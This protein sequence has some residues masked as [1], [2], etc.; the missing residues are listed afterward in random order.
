MKRIAS[1]TCILFLS[2]TLSAQQTIIRYLSG[3]DKDHTVRWDFFCTKGAQSGTWTTIPV[4]SNWELQGFGG[5]NYGH[6]KNK[7]DE[8]GLYKT[9]FKADPRW[10]G[11]QIE[12]VFEGVMTDAAVSVNGSPAG[13]VHQGG[14]YEFSYNITSLIKPNAD[15]LL[16]VTVSKMSADSS[17]NR[18]EREGDFWVFGG[19]YRP[20]YLRI[21]PAVFI[22]RVAIDAKADGHFSM[23]VFTNNSREGDE[24]TAEVKGSNGS[25]LG[26]P[27]TTTVHT[28]ESKSV[29]SQQFDHPVLWNP[30]L[31]NLYTVTI[32]IKRNH[33]VLHTI[34]QRFGFRTVEVRPHDGIYINNTKVV[35]KGVNRHSA[36]PESGRTLSRQI[37]LMDINLMKEMNMN[38]V[39]MSHY[40]PDPLFLDLCDSLGL[41]VLD[42]LTGWQ[43]KYATTVGRKLVKELVI[44]DVNHPS[45]IFWDNGNE[46]GFNFDLDNDYALYDPQKRTVLHPWQLFN[47]VDTKHYPEYSYVEKAAASGEVLLHTEMIHGLYDGGH[48]AGLEDYWKLIRSNP[49]H[50]GG[51]LWVFADEG[52]VRKD[53]HD[54]IDTYGNTAPDGI[55]GPHREKEASFYTIK[56]IWSPVQIAAPII[57]RQFTGDLSIENNYHF[58]NLSACRFSWQLIR[59]PRPGDHTTAYTV[60]S[61]NKQSITAAP[62]TKINTRMSLPANWFAADAILFKAVDRTGLMLNEWI[63]PIRKQE[64]IRKQNL[65][66]YK[67]MDT[68]ITIQQDA[69]SYTVIQAGIRYRFSLADGILHTVSKNNKTFPFGNGPV[70]AGEKQTL[71]HFSYYRDETHNLVVAA[72]YTGRNILDVK[73]IFSPNLPVKLEYSYTQKDSAFYAG[74]GFSMDEAFITGMKWLG[75]GPYRVWKNR[76]QG[77]KIG[78]WK[79]DYNNTVTGETFTYPEFKGYHANLYWA[80]IENKV[81]PFT[82]YS[83]TQNIFLQLLRPDQQKTKIIPYVNPPFPQSGLGFMH[84]IPAIGTKFKGAETMGPQSQLNAP[85]SNKLEGSLWFDFR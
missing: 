56:Q 75:S 60:L 29:L 12:L 22:E 41:F 85:A 66:M 80:T 8:Q 69:T 79:K 14:F 4:P 58:T 30:E 61:T 70:L 36:W 43:K 25:P 35:L 11:K 64:E 23:D 55:V 1:L 42:E 37:H 2:I 5:Y 53:R 7:H 57:N 76:L 50:A 54:S 21:L 27:F 83:D 73:W 16:E 67:G 3:T 32:S 59:Y 65:T 17:V 26:K 15:N 10:A 6:E 39:R 72:S 46:G 31:P 48:G 28:Q 13:P 84:A 24:I 20:V 18:A 33:T 45:V 77:N 62:G 78:V 82:V 19:I 40:P 52:I 38:A 63:W 74:I 51:F 44:R 81:M 47:H 49:R 9:H 71:A 68:S 34:Q